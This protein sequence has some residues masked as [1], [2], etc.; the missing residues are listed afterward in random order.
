MNRP[1]CHGGRASKSSQRRR[2]SQESPSLTR[3]TT[4][5]MSQSDQ[6]RSHFE[7]LSQVCTRSRVLVML[8]LDVSNKERS[9]QAPTLFSHQLVFLESASPSKCTTRPS[10]K[11][12]QETTLVLTLRDFQKKT[13]QRLVTL[14][15]SKTQ[16]VMMIHQKLLKPSEQPFSFKITL[17]SSKP[18]PQTEKEDSLLPSTSEPQKPLVN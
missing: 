5:S 6:P 1:T 12:D 7:C 17:D 13:C 16:M 10:T 3:S 14:C 8:S 18:H 4:L 9:N 2:K 15:P 11:L